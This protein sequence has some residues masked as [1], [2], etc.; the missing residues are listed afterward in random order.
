MLLLAAT[1]PAKAQYT[2]TFQLKKLP[3]YH[4]AGS[5]VFVAGTFNNW[6][7]GSSAYGTTGSAIA[8]RVPEGAH[9]YKFTQ[10]S[11]Q[12]GESGPDGAAKADRMERLKPTGYST[13]CVIQRSKLRSAAGWIILGNRRGKAP[14]QKMCIFLIRL[15]SCRN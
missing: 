1:L 15:S 6:A 8:V 12:A 9:E 4:K 5:P 14:L 3:S 7:P 11:W 10:G 13:L 2:V